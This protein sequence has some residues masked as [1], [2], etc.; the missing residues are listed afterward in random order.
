MD[1]FVRPARATSRRARRGGPAAPPGR[2]ARDRGATVFPRLRPSSDSLP[3]RAIG[4]T[5]RLASRG[6]AANVDWVRWHLP[7]T[8]S[9]S[10]RSMA[11]A[12]LTTRGHAGAPGSLKDYEDANVKG[13]FGSRARAEPGIA[14]LVYSHRSL[15]MRW[16]RGSRST[17][18]G[19]PTDAR[20]A[21]RALPTDNLRARAMLASPRALPRRGS[22]SFDRT[23]SP[24]EAAERRFTMPRLEAPALGSV[25]VPGADTV[26]SS[27]RHRA[28]SRGPALVPSGSVTTSSMRLT[29]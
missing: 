2:R 16:P 13:S 4:S 28:M 5:T 21:E 6:R 1:R 12:R 20:A 10:R 3:M 9:C 26:T 7:T 24:V 29:G 27:T 17:R 19:A 22:S 23:I 15:S 11:S 14:T 8:T 18:R 25:G